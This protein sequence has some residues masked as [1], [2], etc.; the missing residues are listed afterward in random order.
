MVCLGNMCVA[1]R[2]KAENY[3][4]NNDDDD[5]N[6]NNNNKEIALKLENERWYDHL[7][8]YETYKCETTEQSLTINWT[9]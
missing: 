8:H 9:S 7:P 4:N 1:T 5:D 2:H 3:D 6:N